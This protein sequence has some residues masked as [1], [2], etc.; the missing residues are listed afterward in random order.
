[1]KTNHTQGQWVISHGANSYPTIGSVE[2]HQPIA[3]IHKIEDVK[4]FCQEA[5]ANAK[6]IAAAPDML[7]A[8]AEAEKLIEKHLPNEL[9]IR[10]LIHNAIKKATNKL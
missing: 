2:L 10:D 9:T 5:E 1:M 7:D 3:T 8:L 6:L 4:F